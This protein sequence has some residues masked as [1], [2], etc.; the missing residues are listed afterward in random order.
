MLTPADNVVFGFDRFTE[1]SRLK[2]SERNWT[3]MPSR[4]GIGKFLNS[5]RLV[6]TELG[7]ISALRPALPYAPRAGMAKA[8]RSNH[9]RIRSP[10]ERSLDSAGFLITSGR[11]FGVP[12][13]ARSDP[14]SRLSGS[15]DR[16]ET[17]P[18]TC[19]PF[20]TARTRGFFRP[21]LGSSHSHETEPMCLA[22]KSEIPY[23]VRKSNTFGTAAPS[24]MAEAT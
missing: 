2:N 22:E 15:P 19:H 9:C 8:V 13:S 5:A 3:R 4:I 1:F 10:R 16:A 6:L 7:P 24:E 11:W 21:A 14:K 20:T 12:L 18:F 17:R 23:C